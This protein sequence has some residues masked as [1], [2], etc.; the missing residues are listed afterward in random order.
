MTTPRPNWQA[1]PEQELDA[2][3][4]DWAALPEGWRTRN[5]RFGRLA[6]CE[7]RASHAFLI[8]AQVAEGIIA[9][10]HLSFA[11]YIAR[12]AADAGPSGLSGERT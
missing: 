3:E 12:P 2:I 8:R 4:V 10:S 1:A 5:Y 6:D 7:S 9:A 11:D